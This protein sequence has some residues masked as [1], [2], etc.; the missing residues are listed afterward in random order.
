MKKS[1]AL[2]AIFLAAE[3][4][5]AAISIVS[6]RD[7]AV[8]CALPKAA[9]DYFALNSQT[10]I[11]FMANQDF[12]NALMKQKAG[13]AAPIEFRWN[14]DSG[15]NFVLE[16]SETKDFA[17][18]VKIAARKSGRTPKQF[19]ARAF[20]LKI[21]QNY[22]WRAKNADS[23]ETSEVRMVSVSDAAPRLM[24]IDGVYNARDLGGRVGLGNRR[25]KQNMIFRGRGL[26]RNSKDGIKAGEAA[27]KPEG[28][29]Y[30]TEVLKIKTDLDLR[31]KKEVADM[32]GSP[33]GDGVKWI[34]ISAHSYGGTFT[35]EGKA[36]YAQLFRVFCDEKNYPFYVHCIGGADRTGTLCYILNAILG[37]ADDQLE[38]DWQ[39]TIFAGSNIEFVAQKRYLSILEG[40]N[41]FG[42]KDEPTVVKAERFLKSA[43]ITDEEI[44]KFRSIMLP[45]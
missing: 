12:R 15:G 41:K 4:A 39:A 3:L 7:G 8:V 28:I 26:N 23:G 38:K 27:I 11:E 45:D 25:V 21:A 18:P 34:N 29:K 37:V 24:R 16:I 36:N 17:N 2:A 9:A 1:I 19:R 5:F 10:R 40:I 13:S 35:E 30:M 14:A 31:S 43:G 33:L 22:F 6:P 32:S 20:N 44:A 42:T